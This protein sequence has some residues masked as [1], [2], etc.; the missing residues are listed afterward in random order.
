MMQQYCNLGCCPASRSDGQ[1]RKPKLFF[2]LVGV[3]G[4][5]S[6]APPRGVLGEKLGGDLL[7]LVSGRERGEY[8]GGVRSSHGGR[9][10][11][12][13]RFCEPNPAMWDGEA[14]ERLASSSLA[15]RRSM[16]NPDDVGMRPSEAGLAA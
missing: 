6:S 2:P 12:V 1:A 5:K 10:D 9:S 11:S 3:W 7:L 15:R 16:P 14:L 13:S 8:P 4:R